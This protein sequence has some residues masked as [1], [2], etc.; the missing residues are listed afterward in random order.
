MSHVER[1][2]KRNTDVVVADGEND[3]TVSVSHNYP[4]STLEMT[5]SQR[6]RGGV[7]I[8]LIEN[9]PLLPDGTVF[10]ALAPRQARDLARALEAVASE[11]DARVYLGRKAARDS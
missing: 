4:T 10:L 1:I 11:V 5:D 9:D 7:F 2:A 3:G 6:Q 8:E